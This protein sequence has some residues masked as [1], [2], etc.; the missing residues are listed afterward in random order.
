M[1]QI[2]RHLSKRVVSLLLVCAMLMSLLSVPALAADGT[3]SSD[4]SG[5]VIDVT[6]YGADPL[7]MQESSTAVIAALEYA[8][9]LPDETEKTIYFPKGEYHFYADYSEERELYVSNTVGTNQSY[10][11]KHL[12]ILVEDMENVVIDG[13]GSQFIYHGDITAFAAIRSKNVTFTNFDMDH[14]S[15]S[16]VDVT[17]VESSDSGISRGAGR[18]SSFVYSVLVSTV[19]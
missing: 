5:T 7:G 4:P 1:K 6:E 13:G 3:G 2:L 8:K 16:V 18:P 14:A 19:W 9:T 15:P 12:G 10:V 11:N 17:V